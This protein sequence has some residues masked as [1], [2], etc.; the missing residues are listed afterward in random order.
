MNLYKADSNENCV[1][2]LFLPFNLLVF[3]RN[4]TEQNKLS[5]LLF[6][7]REIFLF[8]ES[9]NDTISEPYI[10]SGIKLS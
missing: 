1:L 2:L 3:P 6:P 7:L 5:S 4:N 10:I 8:I 9:I